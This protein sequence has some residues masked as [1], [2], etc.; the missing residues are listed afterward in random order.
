MVQKRLW[1]GV[2]VGVA[3]LGLCPP[4]AEAKRV[5]HELAPR[6][7]SKPAAAPLLFLASCDKASYGK[8][9]PILMRF[10]IR[11]T[12]ASPI[13]VN[14]R[15]YVSS[16]RVPHEHR[17]VF[18][19][20]TSPNGKP[21]PCKYEYPSGVPKSDSFQRLQPGQEAASDTT[22]D[23]RAFFN[24]TEPGR[25]T[26]IAVYDN[27]FGPELGLDT[28]QGQLSSDPVTLTITE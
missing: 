24:L 27:I 20:V 16:E 25:Y 9:D 12:G 13:W 28:F 23:L 8:S 22:R 6:G 21:L 26:V 3:A 14:A 10:K 5:Q 1:V 15:F 18:L 7:Q 17:E 4:C 11:N 2:I 19:R